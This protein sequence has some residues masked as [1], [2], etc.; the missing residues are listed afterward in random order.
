MRYINW[1]FTYFTYI[2]RI[3]RGHRQITSA[4]SLKPTEL[5]SCLGFGAYVR[6]K[7]TQEA[8]EYSEY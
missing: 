6:C 3:R 7:I 4:S 1:R 8:A 5:F 2:A